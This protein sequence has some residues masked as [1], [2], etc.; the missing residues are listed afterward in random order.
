VRP[1]LAGPQAQERH[2]VL[3]VSS[4]QDSVILNRELEDPCVI[5]TL[6]LRM[7]VNRQYV[8]ATLPEGRGDS[9]T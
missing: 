3:D 2:E 6:Q 7:L 1:S 9:P 4:D 8:V 5:Q